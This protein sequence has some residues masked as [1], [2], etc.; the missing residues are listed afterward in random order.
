MPTPIFFKI[1]HNRKRNQ[2]VGLTAITTYILIHPD[3]P[4]PD[5]KLLDGVVQLPQLALR[6]T[7]ERTELF[8]RSPQ[9]VLVNLHR[10]GTRPAKVNTC[11]FFLVS[12]FCLT[13]GGKFIAEREIPGLKL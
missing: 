9:A 7:R 8:S 3:F 6:V 11:G 5:E 12:S 4:D 13:G 2:R 1:A 10:K